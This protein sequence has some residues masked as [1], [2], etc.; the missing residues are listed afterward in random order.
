MHH[1]DT[2]QL[3]AFVTSLSC[4][5]DEGAIAASSVD[6]Y[7][8]ASQQRLEA[9]HEALCID[10]AP[11]VAVC[12][13]VLATEVLTRVWAA[14]LATHDGGG[15]RDRLGRRVLDGHR[16]VRTRVLWQLLHRSAV[17]P[18]DALSLNRF[19]SRVDGWGDRLVGHLAT[20]A[21]VARLAPNPERAA[22][23]AAGHA[24]PMSFSAPSPWML[25]E[26][27]LRRSFRPCRCTASPNDALHDQVA[28][29]IQACLAADACC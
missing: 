10:E 11:L 18:H 7:W 1:R 8:L 15:Q 19:A 6:D 12:E 9:W 25:V 29:S 16:R 3:A 27:S 28:A 21:D 22:R 14:I 24:V 4:E 5:I 2:I 23:L 17:S 20:V 26:Q 13:E